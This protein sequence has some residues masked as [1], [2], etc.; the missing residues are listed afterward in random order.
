V[1]SETAK[2]ADP[3]PP[4]GKPAPRRAGLGRWGLRLLALVVAVVSGLIVTFFSIDLG[5]RVKGLAEREGTKFLERP[6]HIGGV[7]A[8]AGRGEFEFT[9]ITI[10]GL[11][12]DARP[13][14][15]AKRVR[16]SI[17]W[18]TAFSRNLIIDRIQ[19]TGWRATIET[20]PGDKHNLP[21][22][23]P[24]KKS[25]G[26]GWVRTTT[27][28]EIVADEG[29]FVY[30]DHGSPWSIVSRNLSVVVVR[31][32]GSYYGRM[33]FDHGTVKIQNYLP[34]TAAMQA[35]FRFDKGH[36]LFR[37]IKLDTDG[38]ESELTG[39]VDFGKWPEQLYTVKSKIQWPEMRRIFFDGSHFELAGHGSFDGTFHKYR[40]GYEVK[41]RF[42]SPELGVLTSFG[43]YP[44]PHLDGDVTWTPDRL[45]VTRLEGDFFGGRTQQTYTL[46]PLGKPTPATAIWDVKYQNVDA[47]AFSAGLEWPGLRLAGK[48]TGSNYMTWTNGQ[49]GA[50]KTGTGEISSASINDAARRNAEL[51][52]DLQPAPVEKPFD[53]KRRL[54]PYNI[55]GNIKYTWA[56]KWMDVA[57]GSWASTPH[58]YLSFSGRTEYGDN[59]RVPFR[60]TTTDFL[61]SDRLLVELMGAF[62]SVS[63]PI[64]IGGFGTFDGVLT[65]AFWNP[66]I[67][68]QFSGE[69]MRAWDVDWGRGTGKAVIENNYA[70]ITDGVF[71]G[72]YPGS[73]I[74]TAGRYSLG[75]PRKDKGREIDARINVQ[76]WP[77][78]ELRHAF[79][80]DLWPVDGLGSAELHLY[81]EYERP[82]GFG[83][84]RIDN[85]S[86]W[87]ESFDYATA[88]LRFEYAGVRVD[89]I[90]LHKSTGIV[91]GAAFADWHNETYSFNADGQRIPVE[92]IDNWRYPEVPFS[93]LLQFTANG[94]GNF[95]DPTYEARGSIADLYAGDEGIGQVTARIR[96]AKETIII[97]QLEA[98]SPRLSISG[99]GRVAMNDEMDSDLTFRATNTRVDPYLRL[100]NP[101]TKISP[102][103]TASL[104]G[105]VR[106]SG[107]LADMRYLSVDATI[108]KADLALFDYPLHND[109]PI[110][111][112]FGENAAHV[113]RLRLVGEDTQLDLSGDVSLTEEQVGIK[114]RGSAN[115][116]V[117]QA[118]FP[119]LRSSGSAE[120]TADI[121]GDMRS[122]QF[123]GS[124]VLSNGRI[125]H[126]ALPHS[127]EDLN[128]TVL[129]DSDG[130][131]VDGVKGR[132]GGGD[133]TLA[134]TIGL[135]GYV[136][137]ELNLTAVGRNMTLRYP[138]GF[139]SR[140]NADLFLRGTTSAAELSGTVTVLHATMTREVNSEVG[141][142]GLT[143]A[144][145]ISTGGGG[146]GVAGAVVET[147]IPL[148][149]EIQV[150]APQT[151]RI[152]NSLA[153]IV[154]SGDL[155][156]RGT[157]DHPTI[158]GGVD[159]NRAE[160]TFQGN[161]FVVTRGRVEF[162]NPTTMQPVFD[163]EAETR[164]RVPGQSAQ[165]DSGQ[166]YRVNLAITGTTDRLTPAFT[167]DPQLPQAAIILLL[168]GETDIKNLRDPELNSLEAGQRAELNV[169]QG[170]A[171][172]L[173]TSSLSSTV[174]RVMERTL[175]VDTVQITPLLG[176]DIA[177]L[178]PTARVT[179]GKRVS[180]RVFVTY[181][182]ALN[183]GRAEVILLE[184]D[185]NDR[186]SW[187][188]SKNEDQSFALDFRVR[189]RF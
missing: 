41:G 4:T 53:P 65:K 73:R 16:V 20:W 105:A 67:E 51:P 83:S 75:Y 8:L 128:G 93:G 3:Q 138:E 158:T 38:A 84:L 98:A 129:F 153:H 28:R 86:A 161:R 188:L 173:L 144:E 133:V 63:T 76:R 183:S 5:P 106:I 7:R 114:A 140:I 187:V 135:K 139:Q 104:T 81:G 113:G 122:P 108:D 44:F 109:G 34:M 61:E 13:F 189:Y 130:L 147:G 137:D 110:H 43:H 32:M 160:V 176:S 126:F 177:Q 47:T 154:A 150:I 145:T 80:M 95:L 22:L 148:T 91:R 182:R 112:T 146:T 172:R 159:I 87:E 26:G 39:D 92:S 58:T 31:A 185:Q 166:T 60:M 42:A 165:T 9:D 29:E 25:T 99:T 167:S 35:G 11:T 132:L 15:Y 101:N 175:G 186:V 70:D 23:T 57:E 59:S 116:A 66:H 78:V 170:Q 168:F 94:T 54:S 174:G 162:T 156:L 164:I 131:R 6:L 10:E 103:A 24:K 180:D 36:M 151:L 97:E 17:P 119:D 125:R 123:S 142:L 45:N 72:H 100:I 171:A 149:Y 124:A 181:S 27:T 1:S 49:F 19:M 107:E 48:L 102:Y 55:S 46:A 136:P 111:I 79:Y 21:K 50:T 74:D 33:G 143:G 127:F 77:L 157:Y 82:D 90:E 163:I 120:V 64:D 62:H 69:H 12:P 88:D 134:G 71:F 178:N 184:Y 96:Y 37:R 118:F 2:P 169:V 155:T 85:G 14:L 18:W 52:A 30:D 117:L 56:P 179:L 141:L 68:G 40:G 121:T 152:D 89:G 115:L